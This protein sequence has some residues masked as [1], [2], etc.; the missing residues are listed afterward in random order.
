VK[1]GLKLFSVAIFAFVSSSFWQVRADS[2]HGID[3]NFRAGARV[4]GGPSPNSG[5]WYTPEQA[6]NGAQSYQK[7][8]ARCHGAKLQGGSGPA[9]VGRQFWQAYGGRKVSTLWSS[10]HT[11]MPMSAPGSVSATNSTNIM[12]FLLE[13]NGVPSGTVPLDDTTDLSKV[14]PSK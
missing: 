8:C 6:A 14:L 4:S 5:G 7:T 1:Y 11:Q 13:K 9:L 3:A 2:K 10:V 12:A